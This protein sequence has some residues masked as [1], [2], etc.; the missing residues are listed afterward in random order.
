MATIAKTDVTYMTKEQCNGNSWGCKD[1]EMKGYYAT[2]TLSDGSHNL[3]INVDIIAP[4]AVDTNKLSTAAG[5]AVS[6]D[7]G[8]KMELFATGY[9]SIAAGQRP[10]PVSFNFLRTQTIDSLLAKPDTVLDLSMP[11]SV[12]NVWKKAKGFP[13]RTPTTVSVMGTRKYIQEEDS[14]TFKSGK[15]EYAVGF[16]ASSKSGLDIKGAQIG[17]SKKLEMSLSGAMATV[18]SA[19][20]VTVASLYL[21]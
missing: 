4:K 7:G 18:A 3:Q 12:D 5:I 14:R 20:T 19:A 13:K 2:Q 9:W 17:F 11:Q 15:M 1:Y 10:G 8:K 21:I 16:V 6:V